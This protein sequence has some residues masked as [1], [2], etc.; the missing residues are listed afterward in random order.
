M[1]LQYTLY[2]LHLHGYCLSFTHTQTNEIGVFL[3]EHKC[4]QTS[5]QSGMWHADARDHRRSV[6]YSI[7]LIRSCKAR[8]RE[9]VTAADGCDRPQPVKCVSRLRPSEMETDDSTQKLAKDPP[10]VCARVCVS[11]VIQSVCMIK[12]HGRHLSLWNMSGTAGYIQMNYRVENVPK[13]TGEWNCGPAET[14]SL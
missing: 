3:Y 1:N 11:A 6:L 2:R 13:R 12:K 14:R 9:R 8:V 4:R 10:H 5:I 7:S